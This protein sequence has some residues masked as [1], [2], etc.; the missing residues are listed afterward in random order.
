MK[1]TKEECQKLLEILTPGNDG[2]DSV[3]SSILRKVKLS[4]SVR[5]TYGTLK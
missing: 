2:G 1:L 4:L 5:K 3:I